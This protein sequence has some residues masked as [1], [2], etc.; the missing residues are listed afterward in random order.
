MK[1][2]SGVTMSSLKSEVAI[3]TTAEAV[4]IHDSLPQYRA[5]G[6]GVYVVLVEIPSRHRT[7]S[8]SNGEQSRS[9]RS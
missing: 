7:S 1:W 6:T 4:Q 9:S 2:S 8:T 3:T 5:T